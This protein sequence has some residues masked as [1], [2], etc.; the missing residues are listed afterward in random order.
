MRI[1]VNHYSP[2][3]N[4]MTG[5]TAYTWSIVRALAD[6]PGQEVVLCT[7]WDERHLPAGM[8]ETLA[9]A[10]HL[11]T[12][13]NESAAMIGRSID[14]P[15]IERR[16]ATDV[17]FTPLYYQIPFSRA[18]RVTVVHDLYNLTS[19]EWYG[20][21]RHMQWAAIFPMSVRRSDMMLCVS[22]A[23]RDDL[24]RFYPSSAEKA[25]VVHE[26]S[27]LSSTAHAGETS[28]IEEPYCLTVANVEPSKNISLLLDAA[29]ALAE[30]GRMMR[31]VLVGKDK[32]G[33]ITAFQSR[34]PKVKITHIQ[35]VSEDVLATLYKHARCY[36]NTSLAEGFCLPVLEAQSFGTPVIC[37]DIPVL[38]EV[39]GNGAVFVNPHDVS[40]LRDAV[41]LL[42]D[43]EG[44]ARTLSLRGQENFMRFSWQRAARETLAVFE[45]AIRRRTSASARPRAS[46]SP[47]Q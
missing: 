36:I 26:A 13:R 32:G 20:R 29:A 8:R 47:Q 35:N 43:E 44:T 6:T 38:R 21:G 14:L 15:R 17:I 40:G 34:A 3:P 23:T 42:F 41:R 46:L 5:I 2:T 18:A 12:R 16:F 39:A 11:P 28:I 33:V 24:I 30:E 9:E 4:V 25:A 22:G 45:E 37:S 19:P 10:I 27:A 1:L 7:N 31:F